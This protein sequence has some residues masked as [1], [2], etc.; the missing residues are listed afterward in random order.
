MKRRVIA[1]LTATCVL[2]ACHHSQ[3]TTADANSGAVADNATA[4]DNSTA[5]AMA[6][7]TAKA[8]G[9]QLFANTAASSDAFEIASSKL[10]EANAA[11]VAVKKFATQMIA[12]HTES[13]A[14]LKSVAGGLSPAITPDPTLTADQ[15]AKLDDLKA[16]KG[17]D[18]DAAYVADQIAAH[19]QTL[20]AL[21]AYSTGGDVPA[22]KDFATGVSP[23]VAAHLNMAKALKS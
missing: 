9:G 13:T 8:A 2:A 14:K 21:Q 11:S 20:A 15:Q 19:E 12:A 7:T 4:V 18:F 1:L 3:T 10:A 16:K 22:L 5:P 6:D 17:A 23:K